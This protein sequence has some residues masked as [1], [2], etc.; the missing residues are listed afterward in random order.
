MFFFTFLL[1]FYLLSGDL[2]RVVVAPKITSICDAHSC[3]CYLKTFIY[4]LNVEP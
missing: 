2:S 3:A 4:E 1:S